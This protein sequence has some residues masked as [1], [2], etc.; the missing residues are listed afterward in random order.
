M[1][2]AKITPLPKPAQLT[3]EEKKQQILRFLSQKRESIATGVL[4]NLCGS[5][6]I[7]PLDVPEELAHFS[8]AV[9][10]SMMKELFP[11]EEPKKD[12]VDRN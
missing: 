12:D 6:K 10:D 11:I 8:V 9:A 3:E 1:A 7:S 5:G 4:F 2:K